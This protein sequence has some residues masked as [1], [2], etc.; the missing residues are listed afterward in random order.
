MEIPTA[1]NYESLRSHKSTRKKVGL[2]LAV[3]G[4]YSIHTKI[5][6]WKKACVKSVW[7]TLATN[8]KSERLWKY[9][10]CSIFVVEGNKHA[11]FCKSNG[12]V[13]ICSPWRNNKWLHRW[14]RKQKHESKD[15]QRSKPAKNHSTKTWRWSSEML[16]KYLL[17]NSYFRHNCKHLQIY[18]AIYKLNFRNIDYLCR[19]LQVKSLRRQVIN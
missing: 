3:E 9:I 2:Q 18:D 8:Q 17:F 11:V 15:R 6:T 10:I 5:Y 14:A 16:T 19:L 4:F 1:Y 13:K 7:N 12:S